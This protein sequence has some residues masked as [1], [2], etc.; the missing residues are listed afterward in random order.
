MIYRDSPELFVTD[1]EKDEVG[2]GKICVWT[3]RFR[4]DQRGKR[5]NCHSTTILCRPITIVGHFWP[6]REAHFVLKSPDVPDGVCV[7][8][9][10]I[11]GDRDRRCLSGPWGTATTR[12]TCGLL[13]LWSEGNPQIIRYSARDKSLWK[14][15]KTC[16][17]QTMFAAYHCHIKSDSFLRYLQRI[18]Q[19]NGINQIQRES[20][21]INVC[22]TRTNT[23][24][25]V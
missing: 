18:C 19:Y 10:S 21:W 9:W 16:R 3:L 20:L 12:Q 5:A 24:K 6:L 17:S 1:F 22:S 4:K 8:C 11:H 7:R 23:R 13:A 2:L 14:Q 25:R 15:A